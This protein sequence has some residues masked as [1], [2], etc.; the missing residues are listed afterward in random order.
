MEGIGEDFIP[1]I[2]DLKLVDTAYAIPDSEA[3]HTARELLRA[4]AS[5]PG[6]AWAPCWRPPSATAA[7]RRSRSG[8]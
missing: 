8:W 2:L 7:S 6:A 5:W 3:F 4:K 1:D